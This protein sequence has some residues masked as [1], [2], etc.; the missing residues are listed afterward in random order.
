MKKIIITL[1]AFALLIVSCKKEK[2]EPAQ[3][4]LGEGV[5]IINQG[6]FTVGNASISYFEPGTGQ[7]HN[8]L[9]SSV[10]NVPLGDVAQSITIDDTDAY[11]V[12]NNSG[13]IHVIGR[14]DARIKGKI[15]GMVSPR[16]MLKVTGSK[17]YVSDLFS[18]ALTIINPSTLQVTGEIPVGRSTE[19]MVMKGGEVFVA[20]W[21]GY[22]HEML[23]NKILVI[24]AMQDKLVDSIQVGIEP[25]SLVLDN[26]GHLWV[27]CSGGFENTEIPSL[28]KI[29]AATREVQDTLFFPELESSPVSLEIN[30]GGDSLFFL[31]QGIFRMSVN[32]TVLPEKEFIKEDVD[33]IFIALGVDPETGELYAANPFN[34]Q[35]NGIVYRFS[36]NGNLRQE[37]EVGVV[38]GAFAFNR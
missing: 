36:H 29:D 10:N 2:E 13:L 19:E 28:W 8:N 6:N 15:A 27:L 9:F 12:V 32:D 4:S 16:H 35:V 1:S 22:N 23:N 38:P 5:F 7:K 26:E 18:N 37:M 3:I 21:S 25:N 31:N 14:W 30:G 33:R 17:A 24:D 34:Y 20:N 11:V